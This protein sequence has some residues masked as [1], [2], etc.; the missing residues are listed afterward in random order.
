ME[1]G[2]YLLYLDIL[3]FKELVKTASVERVYAVLDDSLKSFHLWE[4]LNTYFKTLYFSDTIIFYQVPQGW[5]ERL[6][7][8]AY[9]LAGMLLNALLARGIAARGTIAFGQFEARLDSS[10]RHELFFGQALVEAYEAEKRENWIGITIL[11]SAWKGIPY[12]ERFVAMTLE[13]RRWLVRP[14]NVLLLNPF[15]KLAGTYLDHRSGEAN[16]PL[17]KWNAPESPNDLRALRFIVD[18]ASYYSTIGDFSSRIA[19]KYHTT[20]AFFR[21]ILGD[22]LFE[23]ADAESRKLPK[24]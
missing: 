16:L 17:D 10:G 4:G 22:A 19:T 7:L 9:A 11:P 1:S 6:F 12:C 3:G 15:I 13:E 14:D 21:D 2:R 5:H 23:W 20:V 24:L 8:D 18:A